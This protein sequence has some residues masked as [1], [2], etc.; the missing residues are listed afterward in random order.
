MV[1]FFITNI[2]PIILTFIHVYI[3][4]INNNLNKSFQWNQKRISPQ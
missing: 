1:N 2:S 3:E 4:I